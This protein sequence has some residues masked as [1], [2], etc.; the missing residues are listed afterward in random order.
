MRYDE[1]GKYLDSWAN[2]STDCLCYGPRY[3]NYL[4][5]AL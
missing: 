1:L 2:W 4:T 5:R 3:S